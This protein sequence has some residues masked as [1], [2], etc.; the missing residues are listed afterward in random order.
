MVT[1]VPPNPVQFRDLDTW[2]KQ[3]YEFM[4]SQTDVSRQVDPQPVLLPHQTGGLNERAGE[5]GILMYE[6]TEN[7]VSLARSGQW[8]YLISSGEITRIVYLPSEAHWQ[9]LQPKDPKTMYIWP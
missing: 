6:P 1:R 9:A 8:D 3:L 7:A 2:A 5:N 4:V